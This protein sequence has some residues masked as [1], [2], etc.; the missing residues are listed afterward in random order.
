M[1]SDFHGMSTE[2]VSKMSQPEL[3]A[4]HEIRQDLHWVAVDGVLKPLSKLYGR[5]ID[6]YLG[7]EIEDFSLSPMNWGN[8]QN[9]SNIDADKKN[10]DCLT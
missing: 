10:N 6:D 1:W 8:P 9:N 4:L 2:E 3:K 7:D 5:L